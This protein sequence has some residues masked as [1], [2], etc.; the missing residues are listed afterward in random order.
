[1]KKTWNAT[2]TRYLFPWYSLTY[3]CTLHASAAGG[4][5]MLS[6]YSSCPNTPPH[7][8][9]RL[10]V[11][12]LGLPE[13]MTCSVYPVRQ[14]YSVFKQYAFASKLWNLIGSDR[15]NALRFPLRCHSFQQRALSQRLWYVYVCCIKYSNTNEYSNTRHCAWESVREINCLFS[16]SSSDC[17]LA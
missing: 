17:A 8:N 12:L 1:M 15:N 6:T 11:F 3:P 7:G 4:Q 10:F 13:R 16:L 14:G 2:Q 5:W 9:S